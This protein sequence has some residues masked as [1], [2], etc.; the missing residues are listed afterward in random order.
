MAII[1]RIVNGTNG[2]FYV[3]STINAVARF[4]EHRWHLK[5]GTHHCQRL[6]R[7]W[8]KYGAD[9]F[10]FEIIEQADD[11][12]RLAIEDRWLAEHFG[13]PHCY[14][15]GP[16]AAAAFLGRKHGPEARAK[17][18]KAQKDKRHRLGHTNSPEH[19]AKISAANRGKKRSPE[20]IEKIRQ[21]MIGTS[22]A[23]GRVVTDEMRAAMGR[24][25]AEITTGLEF[26]TVAAAA[27]HFGLIR[28]NLIR[29]LRMGGL[30]KR[31]PKAGL[32][33][34]YTDTLPL[35]E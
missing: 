11:S 7:A 8:N 4:R 27:E 16:A 6:Q 22:Y 13:K 17:V 35:P 18:S 24:R 23:K 26:I 33:F 30:L 29:T 28:P 34:R 1:Y 14:N 21:R 12:E 5:K 31:G 20:H 15:T 25:V 19:R 32:H 3:G 9:S 2:H 10:E